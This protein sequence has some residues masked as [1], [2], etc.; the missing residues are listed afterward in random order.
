VRSSV[1][2]AVLQSVTRTEEK[3]GFKLPLDAFSAMAVVIRLGCTSSFFDHEL[4]AG[5]G[6]FVVSGSSWSRHVELRRTH[7]QSC[8]GTSPPWCLLRVS[9][10]HPCTLTHISPL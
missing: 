1:I 5:T 6:C 7:Y 10:I 2:L 4:V 3:A 8:C 9:G